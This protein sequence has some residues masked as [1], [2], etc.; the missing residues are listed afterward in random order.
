MTG[1][2]ARTP[3]LRRVAF[4]AAAAP[5]AEAGTGGEMLGHG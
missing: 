2:A 5:Q 1:A 4:V 3:V